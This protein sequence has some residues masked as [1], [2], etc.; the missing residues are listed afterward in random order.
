MSV[1]LSNESMEFQHEYASWLGCC[2]LAFLLLG[3][4]QWSQE[5][6]GL[7]GRIDRVVAMTGQLDVNGARIADLHARVGDRLECTPNLK[8]CLNR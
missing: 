6:I 4:K 7:L 1:V 2:V 8:T 5:F 3:C